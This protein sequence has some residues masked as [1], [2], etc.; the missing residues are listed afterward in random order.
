M[1]P[2]RMVNSGLMDNGISRGWPA[3]S[4][5]VSSG[6]LDIATPV[7]KLDLVPTIDFRMPAKPSRF[8]VS[9]VDSV[10]EGSRISVS[11]TYGPTF[12]GYTS[13]SPICT[14]S[15]AGILTSHSSGSVSEESEERNPG[16]VLVAVVIALLMLGAM[17]SRIL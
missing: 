14:P 17:A 4:S 7:A 8:P 13:S 2:Q 1:A 15:R 3:K 11:P 16:D 6:L 10:I 5:P 12:G 9:S